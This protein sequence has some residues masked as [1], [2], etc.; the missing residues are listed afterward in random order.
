MSSAPVPKDSKA[1]ESK[2]SASYPLLDAKNDGSPPNQTSTAKESPPNINSALKVSN[3]FATLRGNSESPNS[4]TPQM[5]KG[6]RHELYEWG[7]GKRIYERPK[8]LGGRRIKKICCCGE[9]S[10]AL[11]G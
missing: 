6:S 10:A 7:K 8:L 9:H 5:K 2:Q 11:T 3:P 1:S 4:P